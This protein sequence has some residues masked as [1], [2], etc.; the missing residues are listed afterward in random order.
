MARPAPRRPSAFAAITALV[1]LALAGHVFA[2]VSHGAAE[3][4]ACDG[5]DDLAL[6]ASA[7]SHPAVRAVAVLASLALSA[8]GHAF[9]PPVPPPLTAPAVA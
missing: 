8:T 2:D 3:P 5:C 7:V 6:D 1:L 9:P 4:A